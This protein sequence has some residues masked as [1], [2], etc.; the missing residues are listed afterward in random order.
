MNISQLLEALKDPSASISIGE[1]LLAGVCVAILSMAVVFI[2]LVII[3]LIIKIL[4]IDR[5]EKQKTV[6]DVESIQEASI[7]NKSSN[8]NIEELVSV[9]TASIA[10]A[11]GNSTNNIIVRKIQRTNNNKSSWER[12]PK[13]ITK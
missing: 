1:K 4:Q 6:A 9:I 12:M 13:N 5:T 3:S 10:A 7:E 11:T 8:E 2:V